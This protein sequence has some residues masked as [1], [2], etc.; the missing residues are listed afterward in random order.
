[1]SKHELF[2]PSYNLPN[3]CFNDFYRKNTVD[4][5][6]RCVS[7]GTCIY[8]FREYNLILNRGEKNIEKVLKMDR[9][10]V[11]LIQKKNI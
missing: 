3:L 10:I 5:P 8:L 4:F 7:L 2:S 9:K 11:L 1:M 6:I